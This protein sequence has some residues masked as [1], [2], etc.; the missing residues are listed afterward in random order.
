MTDPPMDVRTFSGDT[1]GDFV[2]TINKYISGWIYTRPVDSALVKYWQTLKAFQKENLLVGYDTGSPIAVLHGETS[3]AALVH[4][5]AVL[6]GKAA[7]AA[8]LLNIFESK[9][10]GEGYTKIIG[11]HS[12]SQYVY[13]G[14]ILGSEPYHPHWAVDATEAY[15]RAGWRA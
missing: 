10:H 5:L 8:E 4:L 11:P 9:I 6:P 15:V 2:E 3:N 13:G 1:E 12:G 7:H 14:Y